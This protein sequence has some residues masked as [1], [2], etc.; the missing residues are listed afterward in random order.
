MNERESSD[1]SGRGSRAARAPVM[2]ALSLGGTQRCLGVTG[3][4]LAAVSAAELGAAW[5]V[6]LQSQRLSHDLALR[7]PS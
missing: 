6:P 3:R 2:D 1:E 5:R 4:V 7:R